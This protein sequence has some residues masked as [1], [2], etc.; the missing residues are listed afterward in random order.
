MK[1]EF[2]PDYYQ[3]LDVAPTATQEEI[4]RAYHRLV[5]RYHPDANRDLKTAFLFRRLQEAYEVL[6]N[7]EKRR[8]YDEWLKAKG[9][10]P[11]GK[12]LQV[13]V[14][15][16]PEVLKPLP[17]PQLW[18]VLFTVRAGVE[19]RGKKLPLNVCLVIDR[20]TSMKG[21]GLEKAK[22]AARL[23][24]EHITE[25]DVFSLVSFNDRAQVVLPASTRVDRE[26]A[27]KAI[28]RIK[29]E[30]G[31][32]MSRGI[33]AGLSELLKGAVLGGVSHMILL[34]DGN[35]YGDEEECIRLAEE[36]GKRGMAI[37]AMG[38]GTA[39]NEDLLDAVAR[40]SGGV[41][42]FVMYPSLL[43]EAF[44]ER[45][46]SL[47]DST[48][49]FLGGRLVLAEG[50]RLRGLFRLDPGVER[51]EAGNGRDF[52]LG[53]VTGSVRLLAEVEVP[54]LPQGEH[55]GLSWEFTE[56]QSHHRVEGR[57]NLTVAELSQAE[58]PPAE[59]IE[60][61]RK[62]AIFKVREK[63]WQEIKQGERGKASRRL[64]S[65]ADRLQQSGKGD[66]ALLL[67]T[68]ALRLDR[69]GSLS[70]EGQ[71]RLLYG[72]RFLALPSG[73]DG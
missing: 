10:Y 38:L 29:A 43:P 18:Y 63:A 22:E 58:E 7:P 1:E 70:P 2:K 36:A 28:A 16:S 44:V 72:T 32:E 66:L 15:V 62:V 45:V 41:S 49:A 20:S 68:E 57:L 21:P 54:P 40:K 11:E 14:K 31:T 42:L 47:R 19:L 30:G 59:I 35:T 27:R 24:L 53:P 23:V 51:L 46:K 56:R 65:L 25:R 71:K 8:V 12:P 4:K 61:A 64:R 39:W 13:D 52:P 69:T 50:L 55:P 73:G 3:V 48:L 6:S 60:A 67:R 33:R 5:K 17:E 9:L 37:T 34:T 26:K